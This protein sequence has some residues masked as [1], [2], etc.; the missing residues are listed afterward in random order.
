MQ[1]LLIVPRDLCMIQM[2]KSVCAQQQPQINSTQELLGAV[3]EGLRVTKSKDSGLDVTKM[4][5][6]LHQDVP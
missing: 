3:L 6:F 1:H 2:N 4:V 5:P